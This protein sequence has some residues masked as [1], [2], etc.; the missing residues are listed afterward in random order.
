MQLLHNCR[1]CRK[2]HSHCW[3][4]RG[5]RECLPLRFFL[6]SVQDALAALAPQTRP[7]EA[8][9]EELAAARRIDQRRGEELP[10]VPEEVAFQERLEHL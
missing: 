2:P 1:G 7:H 6:V 8:V 10:G 3:C 9:E 4:G 5:F